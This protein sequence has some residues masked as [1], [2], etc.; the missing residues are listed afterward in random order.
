MFAATR[1]Q[2]DF[3]PHTTRGVRQIDARYRQ[4]HADF[5]ILIQLVHLARSEWI[6]DRTFRGR[7]PVD[8]R[9]SHLA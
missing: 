5:P 2:R 6:L 4:C 1:I 8:N 9:S 7:E 3:E